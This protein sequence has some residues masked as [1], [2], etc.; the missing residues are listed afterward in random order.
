MSTFQVK[1]HWTTLVPTRPAST[2]EKIAWQCPCRMKDAR[3]AHGVN[4]RR[5]ATTD[6]ESLRV[7]FN[8]EGKETSRL[9]STFTTWAAFKTSMKLKTSLCS[10]V[11]KTSLC[12]AER[13]PLHESPAN[14]TLYVQ[15]GCP[16]LVW[17]QESNSQNSQ[18][19]RNFNSS[20]GKHCENKQIN[21][22]NPIQNAF[23]LSLHS[24]W[25][26]FERD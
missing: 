12:S 15:D 20:L 13:S 17:L 6:S 2:Y 25:R 14:R 8:H 19:T 18:A 22:I 11:G 7:L 9:T 24:S 26:G 3:A 21:H 10:E 23:V 1:G 4:W 16:L 5:Q